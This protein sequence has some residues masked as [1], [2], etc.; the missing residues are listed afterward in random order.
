[1]SDELELRRRRASY[2][3]SHRGTKEMDV[4]VGRFAEAR[5]SEFTPEALARFE[6]FI[7]LPDPALQAWI[8]SGHG[9][10]GLEFEDLVIDIRSFHGLGGGAGN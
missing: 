3:A 5:L 1:M 8:F 2:R 9:F 6:R 4:L 7:A 10:E